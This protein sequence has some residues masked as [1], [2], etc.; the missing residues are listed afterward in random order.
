[1]S[2][3]HY[4]FITIIKL[5]MGLNMDKFLRPQIFDKDPNSSTAS[6]EWTHW[7][8]IFETF[9]AAIAS[10]EP[11]KLD[12]FINYV[13]PTA[14]DYI[15]ECTA[16]EETIDV[17]K[18]LYVKPKNEKYLLGIFSLLEKNSQVR[19]LMSLCRI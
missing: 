7:Y 8:R 3:L 12:T 4:N 2:F 6:K 11:N 14:Y 17:L 1:M 15:A 16:S 13:D 19:I 10:L 9:L 5:R 18:D